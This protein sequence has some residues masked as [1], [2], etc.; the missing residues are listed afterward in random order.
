MS[1]GFGQADDTFIPGNDDCPPHPD[2]ERARR[3]EGH[4][5]WVVH[6][7]F[8]RFDAATGAIT[9][10][11]AMGRAQISHERMEV[12]GIIPGSG[13]WDTHFVDLEMRQIRERTACPAALDG[14]TLT[15][16]PVPCSVEITAP[17]SAPSLYAWDEP[18][19]TLSF[20]HPGRYTVR[21]LSVPH[22]PGVFEVQH[23]G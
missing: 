19:L 6:V 11:G 15:G 2:P 22:R 12:G 17:G 16:L 5:D 13:H 9:S 10:R 8:V 1:I 20:D 21:V 7:P 4:P 18:A 3:G 23:D 14:L